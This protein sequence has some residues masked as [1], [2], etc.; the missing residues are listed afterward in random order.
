MKDAYV[1]RGQQKA[2][3]TVG[4]DVVIIKTKRKFWQKMW[5]IAFSRDLRLSNKPDLIQH[6]TFDSQW[7]FEF[8]NS[9]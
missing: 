3:K 7:S 5:R 8:L 9:N 4:K 2:N 6:T 1:D